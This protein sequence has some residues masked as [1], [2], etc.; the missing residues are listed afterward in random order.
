MLRVVKKFIDGF[1][2][3]KWSFN[4]FFL[5]L[6]RAEVGA[7]VKWNSSIVSQSSL[8][9]LKLWKNVWI[10]TGNIF[11][12]LNGIEIWNDVLISDYCCLISTDHQSQDLSIPT[13]Q[14]WYTIGDDQKI[15]IEDWVW[16]G[17]N[18]IIAKWVKIGKN[19]IVGAGAVVT[20][21]V[22][23][24]AIVGGVPARILSFRS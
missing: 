10:G 17:F 18:V 14:Q 9:R 24:N 6:S 15:I 5:R 20:K 22:P 16:I 21:D 12:A 19:A 23:E 3:I 7:G 13:I 1:C 2:Q 8:S 4:R 11:N